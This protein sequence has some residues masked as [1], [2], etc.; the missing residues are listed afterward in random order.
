M[1]KYPCLS[2]R[3]GAVSRPGSN[4]TEALKLATRRIPC[5]R[6]HRKCKS[7]WQGS[8]PSIRRAPI[9]SGAHRV[10]QHLS[11]RLWRRFIA[12][13]SADG[14]KA[15][16]FAT[17]GP[18]GEGG[19]GLSG[20][21]DCVPVEGQAW[22]SDPFKLQFRDGKLYGR[23]SC[24]MKGFL[25]SVLA[26]VPLF[27]SRELKEPVHIIV[28]YDEE[29]GCTGIRPLIARLGSDLP[30]PSVI[31]VGEFTGMA[32][33]DAHKRIDAYRTVVSGREAIRAYRSSG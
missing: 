2:N 18:A 24:N 4:Q 27:T 12:I 26:S 10:R 7:C 3:A 21:S 33:I 9:K 1:P 16:L 22:S 31:I 20:H 13:P 28:S 11:R 25:A 23:G 8:S 19:I 15:S 17:I 30:R 14:A 5:W 29:V 32:V 6:L